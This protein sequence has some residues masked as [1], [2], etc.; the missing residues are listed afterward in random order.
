MQDTGLARPVGEYNL[1]RLSERMSAAADE[2]AASEEATGLVRG[3]LPNIV[4]G[5]G[6]Q[7]ARA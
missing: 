1:L 7:P 5:A 2:E 6:V 3:T 4:T